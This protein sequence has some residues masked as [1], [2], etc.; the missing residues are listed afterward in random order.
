MEAVYQKHMETLPED[1]C[2][3]CDEEKMKLD[4]RVESYKYWYIIHNEFPYNEKFKVSDMMV[5]K[6]HVQHLSEL[7]I[8]EAREAFE[9]LDEIKRSGRYNQQ[10]LNSD[11]KQSQ[12][13]HLHWH[14]LT[15]YGEE[16]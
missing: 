6:R 15:F 2:L 9:L 16:N 1:Y 10:T 4:N 3:F 12:P 11:N 14:L 7:T 13:L 8:K 5:C